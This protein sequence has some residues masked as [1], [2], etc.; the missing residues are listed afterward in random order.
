MAKTK[1]AG[2]IQ[3][4]QT[5]AAIAEALL[6]LLQKED[7]SEITVTRICQEAGVAR[8]TWYR[9]FSSREAAVSYILSQNLTAFRRNYPGTGDPAADIQDLFLHLPF[10][11]DLLLLLY[12][13]RLCQ[14]LPEAL[15]HHIGLSMAGSSF[16]HLLENRDYD[17]YLAGQIS[18]TILQIL[19]TWTQLG[20]AQSKEE[21]AAIAKAFLLL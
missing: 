4:E 20:F 8:Q 12:R 6:L 18:G 7:F 5:R 9:N 13:Q 15:N 19:L 3:Q 21:L 2:C 16:R 11:K 14:P 17:P 10:S 1:E